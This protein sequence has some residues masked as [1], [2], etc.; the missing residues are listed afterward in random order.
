MEGIKVYPEHKVIA[1]SGK[2]FGCLKCGT[3]E[4]LTQHHVVPIEFK[5]VWNL[6]V[7]MCE[8]H[9]DLLHPTVKQLYIP[10]ELRNKVIESIVLADT[11][12]GKLKST[13]ASMKLNRK[14][15]KSTSMKN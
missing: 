5:P 7:P 9:K 12:L 13:K 14:G 3:K 10:K 8:S 1:L 4:N 15:F 2:V 6:K 11:L